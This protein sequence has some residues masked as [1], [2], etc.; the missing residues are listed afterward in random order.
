[1]AKGWLTEFFANPPSLSCFF[2]VVGWVAHAYNNCCC[3]PFCKYVLLRVWVLSCGSSR[4]KRRCLVPAD[5]RTDQHHLFPIAAGG[6]HCW[7]H[8]LCHLPILVLLIA[9]AQRIN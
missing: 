6:V 1:M 8:L 7:A 4:A 2:F 9:I 3:D 5:L